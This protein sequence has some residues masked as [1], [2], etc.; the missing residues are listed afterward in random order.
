MTAPFRKKNAGHPE[1]LWRLL[2][3]AWAL[4]EC[5]RTDLGAVEPSFNEKGLAGLRVGGVEILRQGQPRVASAT[6][7]TTG[8]DESGFKKYA[9]AKVTEQAAVAYDPAKQSLSL[10]YTWGTVELAYKVA[11]GRLDFITT[12]RNASPRTLANFEIELASLIFPTDPTGWNG[13]G[14]VANSLDNLAALRVEVGKVRMVVCNATV[15]RPFAIGFGHTSEKGKAVYPLVVRGG[16][17]A[18]EEGAYAVEPHGLPRVPPQKSLTLEVTLRHLPAQAPIASA[19]GDVID[20][21]RGQHKPSVAWKD[22]RPI[23]MVV[24]SSGFKG[25]VS[26]ANP[27]GWLNNPKLDVFT[28]RGK[29]HFRGEMRKAAEQSVKVIKDTGG[30]GMILWDVEGQENPHPI[31]FIGDPRMTKTLAPEM[32]EVADEYFKVYADAGLR[33]GV[34]LRPSQ[35]YLDTKTMKWLHGTGSD[36]GP[37]RGDSYPHLRPKNLPWYKFYP[38]VERLSDKIAYAKKRWGCTLF[39]VDTNGIYRQVGED[40]KF[41]WFL[42]EAAVWKRLRELHPDVLLIPELSKDDQT[43]HAAYWAHAA[44]Y[45]E[46]DLKGYQTPTAVRD[47]LPGAFSVVNVAD[48]DLERNRTAIKAGVARGDVLMFRGWF[49]DRR[50]AWVKAVYQEAQGK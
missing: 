20:K 48:G 3:V 33:T 13:R 16:V 44:P 28:E 23:A 46:V 6:F 37:G 42:L 9:F 11:N 35:V 21:F 27:R 45:F 25:H 7:E 2:L 36:G 18:P 30:Q 32:D 29:V 17:N 10:R 38:I 34:C 14:P 22:R 24:H 47:L 15:E 4:C 50:N 1:R 41:R 8:V 49:A 12:I 43:Y 40:Q 26:R 39:Y 19:L 5:R 31:S